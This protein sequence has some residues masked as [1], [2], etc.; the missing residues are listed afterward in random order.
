MKPADSLRQVQSRTWKRSGAFHGVIGVALIFGAALGGF[1]SVGFWGSQVLSIELKTD[2]ELTLH[3]FSPELVTQ[4]AGRPLNRSKISQ[5]LKNLYATGRFITL[6]ADVEHREGG[7]DLIL[8]GDAQYFTGTVRVKEIG[9]ALAPNALASGARLSLGHALSPE[10]LDA[11]RRRIH[12]LLA[13]EGHYRS[14]ISSNVTRNPADEIADVTFSVVVGPPAM[15]SGVEFAGHTAIPPARL[16]AIAG[17]KKGT[18]LT[19]AK[20][21]HGLFEIHTALAKRGYWAATASIERRVYNAGKNTELLKAA[22]S[23][24]PLVLVHVEGA[25]VS[26]SE[27]KGAL[28][29][30]QEG[31][32]DDLSLDEGARKLEDYFQR[33]GFFSAKATWRRITHPGETDITYAIDLGPQSNFVGYA[34]RGN[35]VMSAAELRPLITIQPAAF[36]T[37]SRGVFSEQMLNHDVGALQGYYQ[38]EGFLNAHV[39]ARRV[40]KP[41][42]LFVIFEIDEGGRTTVGKVVI[43]GVDRT[44]QE[45][46]RGLLQALPGRPYSPALIAKDRDSM[47]T[48]FADQ[49][50]GQA[51]VAPHTSPPVQYKVNVAYQVIPG[52]EETIARVVILGN[53][54][55]R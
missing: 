14:Q 51:Q 38:S 18:H 45:R 50:Y 16:A 10:E 49:G 42:T 44:T 26:S 37:H 24:G 17:W 8:A 41:G 28:P 21:T 33:H 48:Y 39:T 35:E 36:P 12:S 29:V 2:A 46:L 20:I 11:G 34:F 27:L 1:A 6:R 15:L 4:K 13:A 53:H 55:A 30:F 40:W 3:D 31:L 19:S 23:E 7:V 25:H 47:L 5:T 54:Y 22:V 52:P 32:T 43:R 9:K